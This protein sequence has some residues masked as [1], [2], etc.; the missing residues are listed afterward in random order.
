MKKG[1]VK[2]FNETKGFGMVA[3]GGGGGGTTRA[4]ISTSRSN[5]RRHS[6]A[7]SGEGDGIEVMFNPKEYTISKV[8]VRGWDWKQKKEEGGRHTPFHNK[9]TTDVT[10]E[11]ELEAGREMTT[12]LDVGCRL[13]SPGQAHWGNARMWQPGQPVYGNRS[14]MF[15]SI[16]NVL[17]TK[18]DTAKNSVGNIR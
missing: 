9:R 4:G 3:G 14:G 10:G 18:H 7:D 11:I 13:Y 2:F 15:S 17:K 12:G 1:T 5:I 8:T 6:Y 16:S